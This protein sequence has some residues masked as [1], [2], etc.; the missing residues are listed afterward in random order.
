LRL[1]TKKPIAKKNKIKKILVKIN[2]FF[3]ITINFI[4][5]K[6]TLLFLGTPRARSLISF[7]YSAT[8]QRESLP[9]TIVT[10]YI[11]RSKSSLASQPEREKKKNKNNYF[12]FSPKRTQSQRPCKNIFRPMLPFYMHTCPIDI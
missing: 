6:K 4:V 3:T 8:L 5:E 7:F 2:F 9:Q 1:I 12:Y 11:S 10:L